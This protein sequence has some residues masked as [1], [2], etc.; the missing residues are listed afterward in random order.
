[1]ESMFP[2]N[3]KNKISQVFGGWR[4]MKT[5]VAVFYCIF[6]NRFGRQLRWYQDGLYEGGW[7]FLRR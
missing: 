2:K 1:M 4:N 6:A 7:G 5:N 3:D